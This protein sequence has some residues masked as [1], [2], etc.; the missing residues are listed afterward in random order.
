M[1]IGVKRFLF[2][3]NYTLDTILK[4]LQSP[5][6]QEIKYKRETITTFRTP[7]SP[8]CSKTFQIPTDDTALSFLYDNTFSYYVLSIKDDMSSSLLLSRISFYLFLLCS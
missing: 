4:I 6:T 3:F 2:Q 8:F 1:E 5:E 7:S